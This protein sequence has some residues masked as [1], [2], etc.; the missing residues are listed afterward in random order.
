MFD[1]EYFSK[2]IYEFLLT[3]NKHSVKFVVIGG[4][5]VIYY[6]HSR[7]TGD[8]DI[9]YDITDENI[10]NLWKALLDFWD[11]DIPMIKSSDEFSKKGIVVQFGL[12]PNRINLINSIEGVEFSEVWMG[13][14]SE[15]LDLGNGK[16]EEIFIVGLKDL[17][18]N[19]ESTGRHT[20][21]QKQN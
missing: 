21:I 5:A 18:K 14:V 3:L 2:D 17:I 12:P 15:K 19:K 13:K 16:T 10:E 6:G 8:I 1:K 4:E 9:F 7:L 20:A 11:N